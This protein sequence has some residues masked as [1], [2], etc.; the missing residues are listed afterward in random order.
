MN[1]SIQTYIE[2][3]KENHNKVWDSLDYNMVNQVA[4]ELKSAWVDGRNLF[5]CGN[6]GSSANANHIANDLI[7][8]V[9][10][11]GKGLKVHSLCANSSINLCLANDIGYENIFSHQLQTLAKKGDILITLSGSG[12]SPNILKALRKAKALGLKSIALLGFDGG[13]AL[14]LADITI[15]FKI[16]DMQVSEDFQMIIF[17]LITVHIKELKSNEQ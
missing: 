15:H 3:C 2:N 6:G 17:H 5:L 13:K 12:N 14:K 1:S 9:N 16:D 11:E 8:G 10:P 7:F 4:T